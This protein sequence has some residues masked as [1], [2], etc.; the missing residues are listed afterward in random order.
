MFLKKLY[1]EVEEEEKGV[2]NHL[3]DIKERY[4]NLKESHYIAL[5]EEMAL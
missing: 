2:D 1:K 3:G 4:W 5:Y